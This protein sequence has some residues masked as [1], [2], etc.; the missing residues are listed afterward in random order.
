MLY[1]RD[2][3]GILRA[4]HAAAARDA[5]L[6]KSG[7][8]GAARRELPTPPRKKQKKTNMLLK[9]VAKKDRPHKT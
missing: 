6:F 1:E 2:R 9:G 8:A 4:V 5:E 7:E 3:A